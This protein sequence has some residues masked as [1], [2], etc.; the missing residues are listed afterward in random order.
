MRIGETIVSSHLALQL[1]SPRTRMVRADAR[2]WW[3]WHKMQTEESDTSYRM[4][5]FDEGYKGGA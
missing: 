1:G 5:V 4:H 3:V 2:T